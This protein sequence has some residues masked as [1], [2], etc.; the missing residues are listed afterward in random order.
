MSNEPI[1]SHTMYL[2]HHKEPSSLH[3]S[4]VGTGH[5]PS[6][7]GGGGGGRDFC[8]GDP[9]A[10]F[11]RGR[12][13][14]DALSRNSH[15]HYSQALI[16]TFCAPGGAAGGRRRRGTLCPDRESGEK[17]GEGDR[18][19]GKS[20][21]VASVASVANHALEEWELLFFFSWRLFQA[22]ASPGWAEELGGGWVG[23][24]GRITCRR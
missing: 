8:R 14:S 11:R 19:G 2:G 6:H 21:S 17:G 23:R 4:V 12:L 20:S 9:L 13:S 1:P 5:R 15:C 7:T 10:I 24:E 22:C 16:E 18:E 3:E